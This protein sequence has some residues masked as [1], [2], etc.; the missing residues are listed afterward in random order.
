MV[1]FPS[2]V[3]GWAP[4]VL[5]LYPSSFLWSD[6]LRDPG[7]FMPLVGCACGTRF[8][9]LSTAKDRGKPLCLTYPAH[10]SVSPCSCLCA[11]AL[12]ND[13]DVLAYGNYFSWS[14]KCAWNKAMINLYYRI[15]WESVPMLILN[16]MWNK[17]L[18]QQRNISLSIR[19]THE[20]SLNWRMTIQFKMR[21][22]IL[23]A[24]INFFENRAS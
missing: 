7:L 5:N 22:S 3:L 2:P 19:I 18:T 20:T 6:P 16:Y 1:W 4:D 9:L 13:T 14:P 15:T 11:R 23:Q 8:R 21:N 24:S 10:G 12:T 17:A